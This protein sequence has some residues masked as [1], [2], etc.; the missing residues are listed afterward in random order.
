MLLAG[1]LGGTKTNLAV[2]SHEDGAHHPLMEAT[3]PSGN[4]SSL[5]DMV[6]EYLTQSNITVDKA[7]FG[8]AGPVM[9]GRAEITN[10]SWFLAEDQLQDALQLSHVKLLNDLESI[11]YAIPA[12]YSDDLSTLTEGMPI[13]GGAIGVIAPGTGLGEAFLVWDGTRYR[14]YPSE[15]GH[16]NFSPSNSLE[17]DLL[18]YLQD[19]FGHVSHERV[20]SGMGLP[21]IYEFFKTSGNYEV[22]PWLS[23][24][25]SKA[26]DPTPVIVNAALD[27]E[28]SHPICVETLHIFVSIL[29]AEASNLALKIMATGGIYLGGGIPPRI[30]TVLEHPRFLASFRNKGRMSEMMSRIPIHIVLNPKAALFGAASYGLEAWD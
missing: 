23:E 22:P 11:A 19:R 1:D 13:R 27:E 25:I 18:R 30:R 2:F 4:Y 9:N 7:C 14:A 12:L 29:G 20:C 6:T 8:V 16:S 10:L 17:I 3:F 21:N 24:E 5:E 28:K 26:D 15:G